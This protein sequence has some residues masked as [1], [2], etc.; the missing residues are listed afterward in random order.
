MI[1]CK[2]S[3]FVTCPSTPRT[4]HSTTPM[5]SGQLATPKSAAETCTP[6]CISIPSPSH[7]PPS[8]LTLIALHPTAIEIKTEDELR[9]ANLQ[10]QEHVPHDTW[11]MLEVS[12]PPPPSSSRHPPLP[13]DSQTFQRR[14]IAP[15]LCD[16]GQAGGLTA[17]RRGGAGLVQEREWQLDQGGG[18][19]GD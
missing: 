7:S 9:N 8:F 6:V 13:S 10:M 17:K 11:F 5:G 1:F 16:A 2:R 12:Q 3:P 4:M 18:S 19:A 14:N 15:R